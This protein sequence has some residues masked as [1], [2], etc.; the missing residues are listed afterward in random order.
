MRLSMPLP[1]GC[2]GAYVEDPG[3]GKKYYSLPSR[4]SILTWP[5]SA[6]R[7]VGST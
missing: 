2:H 7:K 3:Q 1:L 6:F 4:F 5:D